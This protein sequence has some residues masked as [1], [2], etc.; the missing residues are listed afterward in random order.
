MIYDGKSESC[1]FCTKPVTDKGVVWQQQESPYNPNAHQIYLHPECAC[2]LAVR[3]L[4]D[5]YTAEEKPVNGIKYLV[6]SRVNDGHRTYCSKKK[7]KYSPVMEE[8]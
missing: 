6:N 1:Y 8:R 3:L 5:A 2:R 4:G 7:I